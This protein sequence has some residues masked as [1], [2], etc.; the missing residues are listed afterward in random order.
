MRIATTLSAALLVACAGG[1]SEAPTEPTPTPSI[2]YPDSK[3]G[4]VTEAY[5]GETVADPYRWMEDLDSEDIKAWASAQ[6][7]LTAS[8]LSSYESRPY[9]EKRLAELWNYERYGLPTEEAGTYFYTYNDG[10][11]DQP[12]LYRA[13]SL[14]AEPTVLLDPN[15]L[16]EDG[17]VSVAGW[18][19]SKD[20]KWLAYGLAEAGS[21]WRV[22][23]VR[24]IETGEDLADE[25]KWVKFSG[26]EWLPDNSGFFY[27]RYPEP[28]PA[29]EAALSNQTLHFHK[30]STAQDQDVLVY[31]RPDQPEWG[32]S[33]KVGDD[34]AHL[35]LSIWQGTERKSRIYH[36]NRAELDLST[37]GGKAGAKATPLLDAFDANYTPLHDDGTSLWLLTDNA[38]PKGRV[39]K[40]ALA[41]PRPEAWEEVIA[42]SED[43]L[44]GVSFVG[45]KFY[46]QYLSKAYSRVQPFALDGTPGESLTLPGIGQASGFAGGPDATETF[47]RFGSFTTPNTIYRMDLTNGTSEVFKAP[48]VD[49]DPADFVVEQ[50]WY[51]SKDGTKVPMFIVHRKDVDSSSPRPTLL[52]GYGGFNISNTPRFQVPNLAWVE[53]GGVYVVANIRGGGEFGREWH[54]AGTQLNKQNVFDDFIAAGEHL[55]SSG[56]TTSEHLGIHGRS[57]GG[58][59]AGATLLQRP[60]LFAAAVP[61]VGVLDM[62]RYHKFTIGW[63]WAPDYGTSEQSED[64]FAALR[65]YSPVHNTKSGTEYPAT[66]IMT[67]DHD[68][69]VVPSHSFKFAAALQ[70]AQGGAEPVMI[71]VETKAGHGAG[72]PISMLV[73][74]K[75]DMMAFLAEHLQLTPAK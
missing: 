57:N 64:M 61:G 5:F 19:V 8:Q 72:T 56:W 11:M 1:S 58:L 7:E 60:D 21:D 66:L 49:F 34:D 16:S 30:L 46:A 27:A 73:E 62:L 51:T 3:P 18:E 67:A 17:T 53:A 71:R 15:T 47:Y 54:L 68:D 20:G 33:I 9:F 39:I 22:W 42:E 37:P 24:N 26:I 63:A 35:F 29:F 45:G 50:E 59:L 48:K 70:A 43:T 2:T 13:S 36:F 52:Y 32:Y 41:D 40:I 38:A 6:N 75:A 65:A 14:D 69:R 31:E 25:I 23:K 4:D 10:T 55:V 12:V 44:T 28:D 74:E